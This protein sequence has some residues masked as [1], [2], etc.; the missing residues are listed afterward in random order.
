MSDDALLVADAVE[1][2]IIQRDE[3]AA[4]CPSR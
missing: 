4:L 1:L 3:H 2:P